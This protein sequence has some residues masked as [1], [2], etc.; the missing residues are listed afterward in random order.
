MQRLRLATQCRANGVC[1][2]ITKDCGDT[3]DWGYF[4][5][6]A[7]QFANRNC[8]RANN[9]ARANAAPYSIT[10]TNRNSNARAA[11]ASTHYFGRATAPLSG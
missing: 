8:A 10:N 7:D 1:Y 3:G 11:I 6:N 2:I 5:P 9:D 4:C